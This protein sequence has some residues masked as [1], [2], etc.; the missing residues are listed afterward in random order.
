MLISLYS[1]FYVPL[2]YKNGGLEGTIC[3][4]LNLLYMPELSETIKENYKLCYFSRQD[5]H[6]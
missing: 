1:L 5:V 2:I 3:R 6:A 4:P